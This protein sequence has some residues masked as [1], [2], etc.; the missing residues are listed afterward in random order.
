M[1]NVKHTQLL[2]L[3]SHS[4]GHL[5]PSLQSATPIQ[6]ECSDEGGYKQ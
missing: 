2:G 5:L 4:S 3:A 1:K 6:T